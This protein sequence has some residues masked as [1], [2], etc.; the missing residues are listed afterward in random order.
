MIIQNFLSFKKKFNNKYLFTKLIIFFIF[1]LSLFLNNK[2]LEKNDA[3][4]I[5]NNIEYH[6]MIKAD[7][8]RY[9][10]HGAEI[11]N[12]VE[13]G[14]NFFLSGRENYT[15]YLP[16]RIAALYYITFDRD[17][18]NNFDEKKINIGIHKEYLMLQIL[19]YFFSIFFLFNS[20]KNRFDNR[21][22][23]ILICFLCIEP[24]IVQ[25]NF[26]FWSESIFFS[27]QIIIISLVFKKNQN[28]KNLFFIGLFIAILSLQRQIAFF[29]IIPIILYYLIFIKKIDKIIFIILGYLTIQLSLGYINYLNTGKFHVITADSK[30]E[31]HRS[32]VSPVIS[33]IRGITTREFNYKEGVIVKDW[34]EKNNIKY[35]N[36]EKFIVKEF[37]FIDWMD[38]RREVVFEKDKISFDNFIRSRS[39]MYFSQYPLEFIKHYLNKS[40]HIIILNPFHI[41]SDLNFVSGEIYYSSKS[42]E[43][44]IYL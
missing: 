11:K 37:N 5:Y 31:I 43:K 15:K 24:T 3:Y 38:Y 4:A 29:Y 17:L 20:V 10:S 7:P 23:S 19:L 41:Y 8:H 34:L 28:Y 44:Y 39:Y 30:I 21:V 32:F 22:V 27:I 35:S 1:F 36:K 13:E 33:R 42:H 12:E 40:K 6:K 2:I 9:L 18:F 14:K 26:S 16:P 25:Y